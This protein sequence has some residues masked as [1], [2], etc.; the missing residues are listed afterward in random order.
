[1]KA[2]KLAPWMIGLSPALVVAST[3]S[4][5]MTSIQLNIR[6]LALPVLA[7]EVF[8]IAI[9]FIEKLPFKL[10]PAPIAIS[11]A[12]LVALAWLNAFNAGSPSSSILMTSIWTIHVLFGISI[13]SLLNEGRLDTRKIIL[14]VQVGFLIS[15]LFIM[16]FIITFEKPDRVW[17]LPGFINIRHLGYYAAAVVGISALG[18]SEGRK[19][20]I[21]TAIFAFFIV[22][23]TVSRGAIAASL[24]GYL[25]SSLYFEALRKR[26]VA[27]RFVGCALTGLLLSVFM[28]AF[29]PLDG[30]GLNRV[31]N[32]DY[33]G[34]IQVWLHTLASIKES[35]WIGWGE[36]QLRLRLGDGFPFGQPHNIILQILHAWGLIGLGLIAYISLWIRMKFIDGL[37]DDM[38]PFAFPT[39]IL[40]LFSFIDGSLYYVNSVFIFVLCL[41]VVCANTKN[42]KIKD[43]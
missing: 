20:A 7:V 17:D 18:F 37:S 24:L 13:L 26:K 31:V 25:A 43:T 9:I 6:A 38:L 22:F 12:L 14:A 28:A 27:L 23:W 10:P 16:A 19:F 39:I 33:S 21:F 32:G 36:A 42:F 30:A 1:M 11:S 3:W 34:R 4:P 29:N 41:S 8:F 15:S 5:E 40:L 2:D 35:P